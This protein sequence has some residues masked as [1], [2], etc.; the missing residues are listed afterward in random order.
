VPR[1][2]SIRTSVSKLNL[3]GGN[4]IYTS[5]EFD[6][7]F[8]FSGFGVSINDTFKL[9]SIAYGIAPD[10]DYIFELPLQDDSSFAWNYSAS[11]NRLDMAHDSLPGNSLSRKELIVFPYQHKIIIKS[12]FR[13]W[14]KFIALGSIHNK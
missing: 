8:P 5:L 3:D 13:F 6:D 12:C 7:N 10:A 11:S 4:L 9:D 1:L 14:Y 2:I